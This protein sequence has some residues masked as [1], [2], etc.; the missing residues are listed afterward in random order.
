MNRVY[1]GDLGGADDL[2]NIQIAIAAAGR[3]DADGFIGEPHMQGVT[4]SFRIDGD[5]RDAELPACAQ[6][7]KSDF[8]AIGYKNFSEHF[9]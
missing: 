1:I 6:N 5:R 2:R 8:A 3:A 7:T 4:V 9:T